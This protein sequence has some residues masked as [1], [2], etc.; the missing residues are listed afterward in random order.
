VGGMTPLNQ[1]F[2]NARRWVHGIIVLPGKRVLAERV[3]ITGANQMSWNVTIGIQVMRR[4]N[5]TLSDDME[6]LSTATERR[7]DFSLDDV[8]DKIEVHHIATHRPQKGIGFLHQNNVIMD[9]YRIRLLSAL[10]FRISKTCEVEAFE[11]NRL[12]GSF[13]CDPRSREAIDLFD[14]LKVNL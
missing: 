3:A 4:N 7:F 5:S 11:F 12:N 14:G 10:T 8:K 2:F 9:I 13:N 1:N 6:S